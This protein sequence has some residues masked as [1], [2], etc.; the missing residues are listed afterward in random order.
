MTLYSDVADGV[1]FTAIVVCWLA[2]FNPFAMIAISLLLA[3]L[4]K[5]ASG[6]QTSL[7]V[8]ASISDIITGII[9]LCMLACEFFINYKL[10]LR[11]HSREGGVLMDFNI[12]GLIRAAV[13]NGTPLLFGTSGEILTEKSGNLNLGVEGLMFMVA[14]SAF[15]ERSCTDMR[16]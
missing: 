10:I 9:L 12:I 4:D 14:R 1:G 13:L 5:G 8:P 7:R 2:Q 15:A 6:L 16:R 11:E 3:V